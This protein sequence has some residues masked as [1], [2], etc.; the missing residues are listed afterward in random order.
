MAKDRFPRLVQAWP[1][2]SCH[3]LPRQCKTR[4]R[5]SGTRTTSL[6][7]H[8]AL[9]GMLVLARKIHHLRHLGFGDFIGEYAALPNSMMMHVEHDLGR[10]FDI[11][12]EELLQNVNDEFHRRVI[13]IQYQDAIQVRPLG[14]R[15]DLGDDG[16][17]RTACPARR[18]IVV[19]RSGNNNLC[20]I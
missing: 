1:A 7:F 19:A 4:S 8:H 5:F 2:R 10:G 18:V 12:L 20:H 13:V 16:C 3:P 14:L 6:L 17:R 11:L 9:Q 15:F